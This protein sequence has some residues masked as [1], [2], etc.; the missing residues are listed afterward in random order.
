MKF[1]TVMVNACLTT[2]TYFKQL[3][4][5]MATWESQ[6]TVALDTVPTAFEQSSRLHASEKDKGESEQ[7]TMASHIYSP[8]AVSRSPRSGE[9]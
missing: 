4:K 2:F 1:R 9:G 5:L 6:L 8:G 7:R 3:F